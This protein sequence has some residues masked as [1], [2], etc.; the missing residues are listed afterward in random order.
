MYAACIGYSLVVYDAVGYG[1]FEDLRCIVWVW[2][3]NT[4]DNLKCMCDPRD[5]ELVDM[6]TMS[7]SLPLVLVEGL[8]MDL[9]VLE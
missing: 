1:V 8:S 7:T 5:E 3:S 9:D 2:T 6:S 4:H